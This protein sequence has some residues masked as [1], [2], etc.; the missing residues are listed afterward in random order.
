LGI[1]RLPLEGPGTKNHLDAGPMASHRV[2]YKG[3]GGSFPQV[4]VVMSLVSLSLPVVHPN[5]KNAP[6]MH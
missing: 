5:T 1:S 4:R 3:E 6:A 2:Y